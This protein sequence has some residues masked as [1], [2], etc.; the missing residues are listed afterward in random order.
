MVIGILLLIAC[1]K[2]NDLYNIESKRDLPLLEGMEKAYQKAL[3]Y[4]DSLWTCVNKPDGYAATDMAYYD[5]LFHRS[6]RNFGALLEE[7]DYVNKISRSL[8]PHGAVMSHGHHG[9]DEGDGHHGDDPEDGH[10]E[11][12]GHHGDDPG[13]GHDEEDGHHGDDPGDGHDEEDG[14]HGDDPGDGHDEGDGHHGD[15]PGDGHD[16]GD[17]HHGHDP[18]DGHDEGDE[19]R[20]FELMRALRQ[21]HQRIHLTG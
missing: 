16:E 14:H 19:M 15:D 13:D 2:E 12:D 18:G 20:T 3:L 11:E 17:G 1:T 7:Y 5:Q 8:I 10:D 21:T 9:D 4:N 6:D